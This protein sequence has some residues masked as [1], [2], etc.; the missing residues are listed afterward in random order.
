[1]EY[2]NPLY[3]CFSE[4]SAHR[5]TAGIFQYLNDSNK[6]VKQMLSWKT[7]NFLKDLEKCDIQREKSLS[8]ANPW[9]SQFVTHE[10]R[11]AKS[12]IASK[13]KSEILTTEDLDCH[14]KY[15]HKQSQGKRYEACFTA[16]S[17]LVTKHGGTVM[18]NFW[19]PY[20]FTYIIIWLISEDM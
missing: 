18:A 17:H 12:R 6:C 11:L 2:L 19:V 14:L 10:Q 8:Y 3:C 7:H 4:R 9:L 13:S 5:L 15:R 16:S 1:M 20:I